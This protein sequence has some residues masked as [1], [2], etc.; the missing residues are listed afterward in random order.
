MAKRPDRRSGD[1]KTK[2]VIPSLSMPLPESSDQQS[3]TLT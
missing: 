3:L 2:S 1:F